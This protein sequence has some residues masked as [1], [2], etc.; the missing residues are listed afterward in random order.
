MASVAAWRR[1]ARHAHRLAAAPSD[2]VK[3]LIGAAATLDPARQGDIGSAAVSA[4]LF[5]G[6]TA[7]DP[8]LKVAA[9]AR[10]VVGPPRRRRDGSSS[11]C[12]PDLTFSRRLADHRR[13]RRPEL[14]PD[15]RPGRHPS[16]LCRLIGDVDGA[17][18]YARG[19]EP[20]RRAVG[21]AA[22]GLDVVVRL[23]RPAAD[24][25][26]IVA[27]PT[28]A[29]VPPGVGTDPRALEP[30]RRSSA[31]AATSSGG[32]DQK[33]TLAANDHYWAGTPAIAD[34]RARPRHRRPEPGRRRSRTATST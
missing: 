5:E 34:D 2:T 10:R 15:H 3:I 17:L 4:Q 22:D 14:A 7:F 23:N 11:T 29:V 21:L 9:G 25:L 16:P 28:F 19:D 1:P 31:A 20:T 12:G 26:S 8:Q 24:F 30:G 27:S 6:L 32:D 13:G 33:T 18:A